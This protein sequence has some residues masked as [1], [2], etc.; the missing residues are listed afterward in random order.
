MFR[1]EIFIEGQR[2]DTFDDEAI[3]IEGSVQNIRDISKIFNEFSQTFT[4]P[5]SANNNRIFSHFYNSDI[6][7]GFDARI[8]H[9]AFIWVQSLSFKVGT[10][11]LEGVKMRNKN[12]DFYRITFI[13]NL[14]DLKETIGD[15]YLSA[16]DFSQ[17]DFTY[18]SDNIKAGITTGLFGGNL[19]F[20]LISTDKQW[21]YNSNPSDT[22]EQDRLSNIA[23]NGSSSV[24]GITWTSLRPAIKVIMI[25]EAIE[26][27]YG[28]TFSRDF[29]GKPQVDLLMLWLANSDTRDTLR[30]TIRATDYD[31]VAVAQLDKG[32]FN[33][34]TGAYV[35][36]DR[37]TTFMRDIE[38]RVDS[39]DDKAYTV[40]VMNNDNVLAEKSG[41]GDID[42]DVF[43]PGGVERGSQFYVRF[44]ASAGKTIES[45][46]MRVKEL[47]DDTVCFVNR[48]TDINIETVTAS[49]RDFMPSMKIFDFI[50]SLF[51]F[52]NL[53]IIPN[54][55][56]DFQVKQ[57]DEWYEEGKIYDV[58]AYVDNREATINR[59]E[60]YREIGFKFASP[61]TILA[62]Q[63]EDF[64]NVGYGDLET[65]LRDAS[66]QTLDGGEFEI[67]IS[68]EQMVYEKLLDLQDGEETNIVYGLSLTDS[69]GETVPD[70]HIF[71]LQAVNV[72][73]NRVGF[74]NDT[75]A[76]EELSGN[77]W[78]PSHETGTTEK[79]S[80]TFGSEINE[81][82]GATITNSAFELYYRD[83]ITDSFSQKRRMFIQKIVLPLW[84]MRRFLLNDRFVIDGRR[85]IINNYSLDVTSG[86]GNFTLL[87]DI[88]NIVDES[89]NQ[90]QEDNGGDDAENEPPEEET[91]TPIRSFNISALGSVTANG[92]CGLALTNTLYWQG[93][94]NTPTLGDI[95]Y[96]GSQGVSVFQGQR[97]Y[98][99]IANNLSIRISDNGIVEDVFLCSQG[100]GGNL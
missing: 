98:Y 54:S 24:H 8:R 72:S 68:F 34:D 61:K 56:V 36:S 86:E 47:S 44:I 11:R 63:F 91:G 18:S 80:T 65:K 48:Q 77:L 45:I 84:L 29:L 75:G 9:K 35:V 62:D 57:L 23:F 89:T 17:F 97:N 74:I 3:N 92:S 64:N 82:N 13:G 79:Y 96:L 46:N 83:Y 55:N 37:G 1:V 16:L 99:K 40:Q 100:G 42:I 21:F 28:L 33:N 30:N 6:E 20:P 50:K 93:V 31:S 25:I 19:V 15:D 88:Y 27:R 49:I 78:M 66:G 76:K 87:N 52:Y 5:A 71:Y 90:E 69:L 51:Q 2:I 60:I 85:Y 39:N 73:E 59:P 26:E 58:S 67:D 95:V 4:V 38:V 70:G 7:N 94:Q 53:T 81:H 12:P 10:I 22:T 41:S 32:N 14:A 43:L